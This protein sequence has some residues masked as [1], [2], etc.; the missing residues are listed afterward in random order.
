MDFSTIDPWTQVTQRIWDILNTEITAP[1]LAFQNYVKPGNRIR[2]DVATQGNP[3]KENVNDGDMP[4][5]CFEP[6]SGNDLLAEMSQTGISEQTSRILVSTGD[7]RSTQA[8]WIR[9]LL[10]QIFS[11]AGDRLALSTATPKTLDFVWK[12]RF[13]IVTSATLD[14]A[15]ARGRKGWSVLMTHVASLA[16]PRGD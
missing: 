11:A 5:L 6:T 4:E 7:M 14:P 2:F 10:W 12:S 3:W 15:T 1:A 9:W 8:N 16:L 13:G